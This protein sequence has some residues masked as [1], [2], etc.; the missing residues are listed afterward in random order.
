MSKTQESQLLAAARQLDDDIRRFQVLS[1]ELSR[2]AV[3]S[4]KSLQRARQA[5]EE[6]SVHESKL[7][8]TLKAFASAMQSVQAAQHSCM[9]A[10]AQAAEHIA[11][12]NA[13]RLELQGRL[14]R[15]GE[16]ARAASTPVS[17]L[18]ELDSASSAQALGPL[19]EV[20]RRLDATITEATE[21]R[22]LAEQGDWTDL[23]RDTQS[24][25]E[26]LQTL[27]NRVLL[28]RRKLGSEAPS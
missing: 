27:R 21:L 6:C 19:A 10:T 18:P 1:N 23:Q 3:N 11:R 13:E 17:E 14:Q 24:L 28:M 5:L 22:A 25:R 12:R 20:E 15:L 7:A 16:A 2:T 26:Q 8:E 9:E 4:E